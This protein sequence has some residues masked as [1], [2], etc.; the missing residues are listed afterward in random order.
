[1]VIVLAVLLIFGGLIP[2]A[3]NADKAADESR[4]VPTPPK[5]DA[6]SDPL[7]IVQAMPERDPIRC[8]SDRSII[9]RDLT[10]RYRAPI[11][12]PAIEVCDCEGECPDE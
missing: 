4:S 5:A 2:G 3:I 1:M 12:Q 11:D 10:V 9:Y 6:V 7:P 8:R